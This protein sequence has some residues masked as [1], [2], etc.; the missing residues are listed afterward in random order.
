VF[1]Y[2]QLQQLVQQQ[3]PPPQVVQA[4]GATVTVSPPLAVL[5]M[6][7][8]KLSMAAPPIG[9]IW[10]K[11]GGPGARISRLTGTLTTALVVVKA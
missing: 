10:P 3:L 1:I 5:P 8:E 9:R 11:W 6:W 7:P 2:Y 4:P